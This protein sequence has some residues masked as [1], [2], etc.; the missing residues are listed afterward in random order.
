MKLI[1]SGVTTTNHHFYAHNP[2]ERAL[3]EKDL[4]DVMR[5]YLNSG[6]RVSFV[7]AI[8]DQNRHV[9]LEERK[10]VEKLPKDI[11]RNLSIEVP[12]EEDILKR[13]RSYFNTFD[14][15]A[16]MEELASSRTHR[17]LTLLAAVSP[18]VPTGRDASD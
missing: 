4:E 17:S 2:E 1:E 14:E 18:A 3:Y 10:F 9:Y 15:K 6:M 7:P 12:G 8:Q 5:A 13:I 11:Q 16:E